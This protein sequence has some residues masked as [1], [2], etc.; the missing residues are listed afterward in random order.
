MHNEPSER[1]ALYADL[2]DVFQRIG[3][4]SAEPKNRARR[5][6]LA[7]TN[8]EQGLLWFGDHIVN[9]P[10]PGEADYGKDA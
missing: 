2:L 8:V 1:D 3:A 4:Y 6:S 7:I 5:L 10:L 9:D